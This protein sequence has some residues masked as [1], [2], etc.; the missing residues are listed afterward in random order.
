MTREE[1]RVFI[2]NWYATKTIDDFCAEINRDRPKENKMDRRE[3]SNRAAQL[4]R[5]GV[6]LPPKKDPDKQRT[7]RK[8]QLS[9]MDYDSLKLFALEQLELVTRTE[10]IQQGQREADKYRNYVG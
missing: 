4:R 7:K 6:P 3:A 2:A 5:Q 1:A 8:K 10:K 9:R